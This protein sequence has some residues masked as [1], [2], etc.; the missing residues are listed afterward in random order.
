[1]RCNFRTGAP[2]P[3]AVLFLGQHHR[4]VPQRDNQKCGYEN[5][6]ILIDSFPPS[7]S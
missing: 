4:P 5:A 3:N 2:V 6:K 1:M 7:I